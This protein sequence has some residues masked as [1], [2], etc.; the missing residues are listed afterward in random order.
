[1]LLGQ[2]NKNKLAQ[3]M[4]EMA[5]LAPLVLI[6]VGI[7]VTYAAKMNGDQY[8][9][10]QAFRRALKKSHD[11]NKAVAY[12]T[13]D[14]RRQADASNP[15]IGQKITSSGSGAVMWAIPSVE[16]QGED[17]E[18]TLWMGVN[19]AGGK[20]GMPIEYDLGENA[21]SGG[22][23]PMYITTS[24]VNLSINRSDGSVSSTRSG[25]VAEVMTYK[26]D[27]TRYPQARGSGASRSLSGGN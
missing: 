15:I 21:S 14:D 3:A 6:A 11:D 9:L 20:F 23:T 22:I 4:M 12:G 19:S 7:V 25:G 16:N 5:V 8:Q 13:W 17:P 10:M 26:M 24:S 27:D 1:M 2:R 18:K